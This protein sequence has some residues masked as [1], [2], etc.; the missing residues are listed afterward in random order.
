MFFGGTNFDFSAGANDIGVAEYLSGDNSYNSY[1][2]DIT[3]YDYDAPMD[4]AGDPT[5]KY[6]KI[7]NVI[8]DFLTLPELTIPPKTQ[9]MMVEPIVLQPV[10]KLLN[11]NTLK[12]L[13]VHSVESKKPQSFEELN[14]FSGLVLYETILPKIKVDPS[15][16]TV[17]NLRDR[18]FA[19]VDGHFVGTL[20][21]ENKIFSLP[22]HSQF[23]KK[24][25]L[26]VENQGRINFHVANDTKGI[27]GGV[28]VTQLG[29]REEELLEWNSFSLPLEIAQI[30]KFL[31]NHRNDRTEIHPRGVI[32][33]G[34]VI[35][36][37][38]FVLE[39]VKGDTYIDFSEWG[40]GVV[41]VNGFNLGRYWPI[42]G[43]QLTQ[44][45]PKELMKVGINE[46][47]L[48]EYQR[49]PIGNRL[50]F[51]PIPKLDGK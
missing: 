37:G 7:R 29:G 10:G 34:P 23:G 43:P 51:T 13:A 20:S 32:M 9:K 25:Q 33:E 49:N 21:R 28:T 30:D 41:F 14:Q 36:L 38:Q 46:V 18:A 39:S 42:V 26:L 1:V 31:F 17:K 6:L 40:K 2:A 47:V 45:I 11:E 44:F 27:F 48:I 4:E 22:L 8:K 16:L 12:Y 50:K 35:F 24:I 15:L 19:F 5:I 3:S